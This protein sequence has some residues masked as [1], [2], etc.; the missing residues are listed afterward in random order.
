[1]HYATQKD[2]KSIFIRVMRIQAILKM[3]VEHAE[4]VE[5][6]ALFIKMTQLGRYDTFAYHAYR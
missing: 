4:K 5:Q 6:P 3:F 2:W 1:M